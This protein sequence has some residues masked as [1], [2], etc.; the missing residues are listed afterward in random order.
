MVR[1]E[2]QFHFVT[3]PSEAITL[4]SRIPVA[5]RCC[6]SGIMVGLAAMYLAVLASYFDAS[7]PPAVA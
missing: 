7:A 5:T 2:I 4:V 6:D 3:N 1:F